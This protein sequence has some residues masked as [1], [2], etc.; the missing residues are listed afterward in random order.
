MKFS[1]L[2]LTYKP[3][4]TAQDVTD[5]YQPY[6]RGASGAFVYRLQD[7]NISPAR[8]VANS[9]VN[10]NAS[11]KYTVQINEP[12]VCAPEGDCVATRQILGTDLVK[13][14]LRFLA[15]TTPQERYTQIA[16]AKAALDEFEATIA[17]REVI[18]T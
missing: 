14:E 2:E 13:I 12:R 8:I 1:N 10:D 6:D 4:G 9:S 16:R 17:Q 11:D 18:Y 3:T 7:T 5:V 15:T